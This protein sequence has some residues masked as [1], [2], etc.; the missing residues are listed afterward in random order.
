ML[1][2]LETDLRLALKGINCSDN[3]QLK[4][5]RP[6]QRPSLSTNQIQ[7]IQT[8]SLDSDFHLYYQPIIALENSKIVSFESLLRWQHRTR[9][10]VSPIEFIP[11]AEETGLISS[12]GMWVMRE[13]CSQMRLWQQSFPQLFPLSVIVNLSPTQLTQPEVVTQ[14]QTILEET[15]LDSHYLKL[16]VT[17]S[18]LIDKL[19]TAA[20]VLNELRNSGIKLSIDDFGTGYS[21]LMRLQNFPFHTLKI[22]RSFV[23]HLD[24][25]R[26]SFKIVEAI[27]SL[28]HN[29]NMDVVAEG[30]E[31][32][33]QLAI[34]KQLNCDFGQGYLF[35]KPIDVSKVT[36]LLSPKNSVVTTSH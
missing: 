19:E 9:G 5:F 18:S 31:T 27:I 28:A 36:S 2:Q 32:P 13:A 35:S 12:L 26:R 14:I 29:L 11:L 25:D 4:C 8:P 10:L 34:L 7:Q 16:E 6:M 33:Q 21:S 3:D 30:I 24:Q 15:G 17:E 22:D 23:M 20:T 1:W